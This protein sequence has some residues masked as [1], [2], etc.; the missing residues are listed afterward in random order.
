MFC[1]QQDETSPIYLFKIDDEATGSASIHSLSV[2][3]EK[4]K[5]TSNAISDRKKF[6]RFIYR[7]NWSLK[8]NVAYMYDGL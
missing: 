2:L 6:C 7:H 8:P 3:A 4:K 1:I 5:T